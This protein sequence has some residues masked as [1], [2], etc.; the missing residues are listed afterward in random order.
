MKTKQQQCFV[1]GRLLERQRGPLEGG[2]L[3][4]PSDKPS[5]LSG[6]AM[7]PRNPSVDEGA[8][9]RHDQRVLRACSEARV[10]LS[11]KVH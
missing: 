7:A 2:P 6:I 4:C 3:E 11:L 9:E 8:H 10:V 1:L 5:S